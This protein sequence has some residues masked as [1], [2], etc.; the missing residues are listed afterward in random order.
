V[1]NQGFPFYEKMPKKWHKH[2]LHQGGFGVA[3]I[4]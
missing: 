1:A 4:K 3:G 2:A